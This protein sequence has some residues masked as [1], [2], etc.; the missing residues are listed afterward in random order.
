MARFSF[1]PSAAGGCSGSCPAGCWLERDGSGNCYCYCGDTGAKLRGL[2]AALTPGK[3]VL[4]TLF[5]AGAAAAGKLIANA[6]R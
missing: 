2:G 6:L 5:L 3:I 4:G 1:R